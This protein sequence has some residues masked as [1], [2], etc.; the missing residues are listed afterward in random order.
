MIYDAN[1]AKQ[2]T[3]LNK[4]GANL[5]VDGLLGPLTQAAITKYSTPPKT[6]A[7]TG[8]TSP[9]IITSKAATTDLN[10]I[11]NNVSEINT[12]IQTQ[13][14]KNAQ[15][16]LDAETKATAD[17]AAKTLT[18]QKNKELQIKAD[19]LKETGD[20]TIGTEGV[21]KSAYELKLAQTE[22]DYFTQA[23][24]VSKTIT[25]IQ[26]GTVPLSA[27]EQAQID[28]LKQQF[29]GLIED[30][31]L[32]NINSEGVANIRGF[33]TGSAEYDPTFQVKTIGSIVTA[34]LNKV[35]DLNIKMASAVATMTQGFKDNNINAIK[36]S[37]AIYTDAVE[38]RTASIQKTIDSANAKIKEAKDEQAAALKAKQD[39]DKL[40]YEQVT[41]PI[42]DIALIAQ[43]YNAS[44]ETVKAMLS[45][46]TYEDAIKL[47]GNSLTDPKAKYELENARLDNILKQEEI[48]KTRAET[49][50]IGQ[51]TA[52]EKKAT[53]AEEAQALAVIPE[54]QDK[55]ANVD[56]LLVHPGMAV[57]VGPSWLGRTTPFTADV[58][59][60]DKADFIAGVE[61]LV[62]QDTMNTLLNL[63]AK[64]G[65]LGA[66]S[67]QER[68]M[69]RS[70]STKIG[71]WS[72]TNKEGKVEGYAASESSFKK[73]LETIKLL[74]QR[75]LTKAQGT[76]L[77]TDEKDALNIYFDNK[78]ALEVGQ[79]N[80]ANYYSQ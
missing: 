80:P 68:I 2:Q 46:T 36:E 19:A 35:A 57:S 37:W 16:K 40:H 17:A 72:I 12:G 71:S 65:T 8:M 74:S 32:T 55:I 52:A 11:K 30:Q 69:L 3:E 53:A 45:A 33:Q 24:N 54:L 48:K 77:S 21:K 49:N 73:E 26:N 5:K 39:A 44:P 63:K 15:I 56:E 43:K 23:E 9:S 25:N 47:A 22:E 18:D 13:A 7:D 58:W 14:Q 4:Q 59:N 62:S 28:G 42:Q 61:K 64:G 67:D 70:A 51:P 75:A 66:L 78:D 41:K 20:T 50:Q 29:Q 76:A 6:V 34:G 27:G 1:V 79:F 10:N 60:G 31:K 38:K